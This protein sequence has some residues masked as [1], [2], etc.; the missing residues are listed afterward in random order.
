[1]DFDVVIVGAGIS[2]INAAYRIQEQGPPGMSYVILE[3][4]G[5]LGG[6]VSGSLSN[7]SCLFTC[8]GATGFRKL[9]LLQNYYMPKSHDNY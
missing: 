7:L 3:G 1:M 2:G 6:T 5:S 4:R 8:R 9:Q